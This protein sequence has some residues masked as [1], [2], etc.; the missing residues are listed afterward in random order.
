MK[1]EFW[2]QRWENDE[3]GFHL[4]TVNPLL[5]EH[6]SELKLSPQARVLIPMCGKTQDI[7]WLLAKGHRVAGIELSEIAITQF[8]DDLGL[9]PEITESGA[10]QHYRAPSIDIFVGDVFAVTSSMLGPIDAVYDRGALVALPLD[11]RTQYAPHLIKVTAGAP[12]LVI[13]YDYDQKQME[14]PPFSITREEL[15]SHYQ[16]THRLTLLAEVPVSDHLAVSGPI[17]ETVWLLEK[18]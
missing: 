3:V 6:F 15:S 14:G 18:R 5:A 1:H 16:D 9:T 7:P 11:M 10:L 17:T 13:A 2:T 12:Q 4:D 8:F